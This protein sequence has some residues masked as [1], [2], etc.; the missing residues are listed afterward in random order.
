MARKLKQ[1]R[2]GRN[3]P[4]ASGQPAGLKL[5][6]QER[7]AFAQALNDYH[8]DFDDCFYRQE[9]RRW[10]ALYLCGQLSNLERKTIEPMVLGLCGIQP[11]VVRAVQGFIGSGQWEFDRLVHRHQAKA[12]ISLGDP[13]GVVIVDGS[14]FPKQGSTRRGWPISIVA[15]WA[16]SRIAKKA[17]LW[18]TPARRARLS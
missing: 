13:C 12:A 11:N 9:Q 4:P 2:T 10:S 6:A 15:R 7:E 18:C 16:K 8:H 1:H 5:T 3:Q 14:G 17:C